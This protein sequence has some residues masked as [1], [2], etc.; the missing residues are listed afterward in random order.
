MKTTIL[1]AASIAAVALAQSTLAHD[2][3]LHQQKA[4][5]VAD[6]SK[7]KD[8]EMS[9]MDLKDPVVMA[10]HEKC[11]SESSRSAAH[12]HTKSEMHGMQGMDMKNM[13]MPA[14][15]PTTPKE[16]K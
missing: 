4:A 2:P 12:S 15:A 8:M 1:F 14:S 13:G 6:C 16:K 11:K 9:K 5:T 3:K 7:M 10:M